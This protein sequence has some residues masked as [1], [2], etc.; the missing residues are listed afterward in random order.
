VRAMRCI[1]GGVSKRPGLGVP[2]MTVSR[3]ARRLGLDGNPLRRRTDKIAVGLAALLVVV[4]LT[5]APVVSMVAIGAAGRMAAGQ[6]VT[7][8]W[9]QVS[10][11]VQNAA[12]A[13][14][15]WEL[16]GYSWVRARWIAPDGR[17]RAGQIPVSTAVAVGQTV[18]VWVNAA[19]TPTGPL[20]NPGAVVADQ[21]AA[22]L[23]AVVTLGVT[24]L[25]LACAVRWALDR[26]RL[27]KWETEWAAVGPPWTRRFQSRG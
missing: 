27:A 22:A 14:P 11:V 7:R 4:F 21:A 19:G 10:A 1:V 20:P 3:L 18:R 13:P 17:A 9:R 23:A 2:G 8:S 5:A 25:C 12:P 16:S 24:L 6:Q 26:R 15:A